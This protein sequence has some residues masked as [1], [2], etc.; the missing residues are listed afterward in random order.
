[1]VTYFLAS[2]IGW[3]LVIF[4][5]FL[6]LRRSIAKSAMGEIMAQ[7]GLILILAV[8]TVILGLL[9]V[10]S[11]NVWVMGWPIILTLFSWLVLIVG[12][13]RLFCPDFAIKMGQGFIGHPTR[14]T[15]AGVIFLIVGLFL[16][17]MVYFV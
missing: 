16:L 5:L 4:S 10:I 12:L 1:M 11:H 3:Y 6:L 17:Y 15:V 9:M 13:L 7:P 8:I 2:V 14:M